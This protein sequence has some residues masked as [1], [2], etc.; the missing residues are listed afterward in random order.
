MQV[1][2]YVPERS[3]IRKPIII[4]LIILGGVV[5]LLVISALAGALLPV[6]RQRVALLEVKGTIIDVSDI[7]HELHIY[8]DNPMVKAIVVRLETPGGAAGASQELY[9]EISKIH[10]KRIKPIIVSMGNVAASGGYYVACGADEIYANPGTLTGSIGVIMNFTNWERLVRKV[11]LRFEV[12]KSG[13][14]KDIGSPNR[15]MTPEEHRLLQGIIDDVYNQ[16]VDAIYQNRRAKLA[17]AFHTLH[18]DVADSPTTDVV[19]Q[20]LKSIADGRIFSGRQA[21]VYGLVDKLGNLDDAI[22]R[23]AALAGIKGRPRIYRKRRRKRLL[24]LLTGEVSK[25]LRGIA[26]DSPTLE[27]RLIYR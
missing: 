1:P 22:M 23:A 26:A 16:F 11:G 17:K 12:V 27:Y 9:E 21:Y 25:T 5:F 19:K 24:D 3:G 7:I 20:Y 2:E 13:K 4:I 10:A 6:L 15:P 18:P 14:H 8:R